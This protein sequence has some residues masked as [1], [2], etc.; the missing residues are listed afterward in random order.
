MSWLQ[1]LKD[2]AEQHP[3]VVLRFGSDEWESLSNSRR[4]VGEFT[5]AL[6]HALV[7][8][9][10]APAPCLLLGKD[11]EAERVPLALSSSRRA[12]PTLD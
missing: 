2:Y 6:P 12:R 7:S 10:K 4:G 11:G 8:G 5:V 3:I 1:T 9:V